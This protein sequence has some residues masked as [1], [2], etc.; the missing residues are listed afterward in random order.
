[1]NGHVFHAKMNNIHATYQKRK[2]YEYPLCRLLKINQLLF[3]QI[4]LILNFFYLLFLKIKIKTK[5]F[6]KYWKTNPI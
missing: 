1:M 4:Y 5:S 3:T 6:I 2:K